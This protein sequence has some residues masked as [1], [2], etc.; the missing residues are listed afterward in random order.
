MDPENARRLLSSER[1]RLQRLLDEQGN[2]QFGLSEGAGTSEAG[3]MGADAAT[4]TFDRT[5]DQSVAGHVEAELQEVE[6]A[7]RRLD[8]G[9]Y[10]IC[11]E[12]GEPI[13]DERL[14]EMPATRYTVEGQRIAEG[15]RGV[16]TR[17]AG[18]PT[19]TTNTRSAR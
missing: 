15:R 9:T 1:D 19:A 11:E 13:P 3:Q 10:G 2:D 18:D 12:T 17:G 8:E 14:E 7:L 4:E 5:V 16:D 6:G